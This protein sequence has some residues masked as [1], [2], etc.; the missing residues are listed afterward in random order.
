[1]KK[2]DNEKRSYLWREEEAYQCVMNKYYA[3]PK[4]KIDIPG[5]I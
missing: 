4:Q 2:N 5:N 3:E 1:L